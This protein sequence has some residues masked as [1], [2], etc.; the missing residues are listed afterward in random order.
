MRIIRVNSYEELS[1]RAAGFISAQITLK[2]DCV[3]GLATGTTPKGTYENLISL[4]KKGLV[5]FSQVR[6]ANLDEYAGLS[7]KDPHSY[8]YFMNTE[9]FDHVN[10]DKEHTFLPD[11]LAED[12][13]EECRQYE[14]K[15]KSLEG[16]DLQLLG[17][18]HNGHIGFNEP[19]KEFIKDTHVVSLTESTIKANSR[20]FEKPEDVPRKAVT[21]GIGT[22]MGAARL[23]LI[24][25]GADKREALNLVLNGPI[26]PECPASVL[27]L[28]TDLVVIAD[29]EAYPE[30]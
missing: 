11:G 9:L 12:L 29:K 24:V 26:C 27:K 6:T 5:D 4:Y 8:R 3:L 22:I 30:E 28:H 10:I 17:L 21:M 7:P 15:I 2:P 13:L 16:I 18:G 25:S 14:A 23:L 19:A 20:L 1:E